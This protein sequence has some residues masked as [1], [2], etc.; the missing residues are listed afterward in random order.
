MMILEWVYNSYSVW[1]AF[2][3]FVIFVLIQVQISMR[4]FRA[5]IKTHFKRGKHIV[6]G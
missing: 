4:I 3:G 5:M 2:L 1:A 6:D